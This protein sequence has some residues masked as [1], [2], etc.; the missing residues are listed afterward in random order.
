MFLWRMDALLIK[1]ARYSEDKTLRSYICF[2]RS[3]ALTQRLGDI[4]WR[5]YSRI[6]HPLPSVMTCWRGLQARGMAGFGNGLGNCLGY[7]DI[8][9]TGFVME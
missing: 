3:Y 6:L 5:T 2:C 8:S 7:D 4:L 1:K 9:L